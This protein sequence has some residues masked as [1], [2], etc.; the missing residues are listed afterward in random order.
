MCRFC[1]ISRLDRLVFETVQHEELKELLI[2]AVSKHSLLDIRKV[3]HLETADKRD[4]HTEATVRSRAVQANVDTVVDRYPLRFRLI[5]LEAII[6]RYVTYIHSL[7]L[8]Q[9]GWSLIARTHALI[10]HSHSLIHEEAAICTIVVH[11]S[12]LLLFLA[13]LPVLPL[14]L[15][16][17]II[18]ISCINICI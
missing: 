10:A 8:T 14:L 3:V 2:A 15:G 6:I 13:R 11:P 1:E 17:V 16:S 18:G 5:A 7:L 9:Q 4:L 12:Y